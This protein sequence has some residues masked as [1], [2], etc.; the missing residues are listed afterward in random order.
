MAYADVATAV[1]RW[2][3]T[4]SVRNQ[5]VN[6]LLELIDLKHT[7]DANKELQQK[8]ARRKKNKYDFKNI[9]SLLRSTSNPFSCATDK[10]VL[11]NIKTGR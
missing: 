4:N 10:Y 2:V 3:V 7:T 6:S 1:N 5:L 9:K 8:K 11:F